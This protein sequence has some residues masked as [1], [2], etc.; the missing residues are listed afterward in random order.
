MSSKRKT[1]SFNKEK[2]V[3]RICKRSVNL[4]GNQFFDN[5]Q[6]SKLTKKM[7]EFDK[8]MGKMEKSIEKIMDF[9]RE[10]NAKVNRVETILENDLKKDI[11]IE[12]LTHNLHCMKLN[13]EE[14]K[15]K[16]NNDKNDNYCFYS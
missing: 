8:R 11:V 6:N 5:F 15:Y 7:E 14:L 9:M 16:L 12:D 1:S 4:A 10:I 3:K 13:N 2:I